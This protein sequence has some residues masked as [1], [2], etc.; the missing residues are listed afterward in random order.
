MYWRG[1]KLETAACSCNSTNSQLI[2]ILV[3]FSL[4][5]WSLRALLSYLSRSEL[6]LGREPTAVVWNKRRR[7]TG[8]IAAVIRQRFLLIYSFF[9]GVILRQAGLKLWVFVPWAHP[10][11]CKSLKLGMG[12]GQK[13]PPEYTII[14]LYMCDWWKLKLNQSFSRKLKNI[15]IAK[16]KI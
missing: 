7:R 14:N 15:N 3:I 4:F 13:T 6:N 1:R 8:Q 12:S 9:A 2:T 5:F 10:V 16:A 11:E